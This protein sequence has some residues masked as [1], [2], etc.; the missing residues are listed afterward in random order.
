MAVTEKK[1]SFDSIYSVHFKFRSETEAL[2]TF[3][4]VL[5]H[6]NDTIMFSV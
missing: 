2:T 1:S 3:S 4:Q 6:S 5:I